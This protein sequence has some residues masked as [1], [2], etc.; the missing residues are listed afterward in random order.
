L[1]DRKDVVVDEKEDHDP[2]PQNEK[3]NAGR[4]N[5]RLFVFHT[6][7]NESLDLVME[8]DE[9]SSDQSF[10]QTPNFQIGVQVLRKVINI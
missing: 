1:E 8:A 4:W 3:D 5:L 7:S 9:W 2:N 6:D 10:D